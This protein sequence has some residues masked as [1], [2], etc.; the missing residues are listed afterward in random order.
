MRAALLVGCKQ[1]ALA[2]QRGAEE[3]GRALR[4]GQPCGLVECPRGTRECAYHQ[5][6]PGS[7]DL[8]VAGG[9]D[10]L[11]AC[12]K[13]LGPCLLEPRLGGVKWYTQPA[14]DVGERQG[15]A[16]VPRHVLEVGRLVE[17]PV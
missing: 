15:N 12:G 16:Q 4:R 9:M 6:V 14:C 2:P 13:E 1:P 3:I 11:L 5:R 7:E 8:V 17:P 10:A